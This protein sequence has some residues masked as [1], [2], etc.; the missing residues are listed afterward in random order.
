MRKK[1]TI[2]AI[3]HYPTSTKAMENIE[4]TLRVFYVTQVEKQLNMYSLTR[5][6]KVAVVNQLRDI[7]AQ[8]ISN[9][10]EKESVLKEAA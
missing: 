3:L 2:K 8:K 7:Y 10:S 4:E 5:T 9:G 1:Q 6:Q